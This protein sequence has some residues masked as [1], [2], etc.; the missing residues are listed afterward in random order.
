MLILVADDDKHLRDGLC[1][2]LSDQGYE[3]CRA[4]DGVEAL[5]LCQSREP[6]LCILDVMMP[7]MDG[8]QLCALLRKRMPTVSILLLT[9]LDKDAD[10][11]KGLDLGADDYIAKP[12]NPQTLLARVRALLR[13]NVSQA[14]AEPEI[15]HCKELSVDTGKLIASYDS[16]EI[17]LT[18][19]EA[20]FLVLMLR[21]PNQ[22]I[23]RDQIFDH[24]WHKDYLPSSRSLDQFVLTLRHKLEKILG[25]PRLIKSVYGRGYSFKPDVL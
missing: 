16:N 18:H 24:C 7:R 13:R 5:S 17:A 12:F 15:L 11:V 1:N 19:R 3:C 9:A 10:Q 4:T 22:V 6:D 2:L 14:P 8:M 21:H 20:C 25:T 23:S